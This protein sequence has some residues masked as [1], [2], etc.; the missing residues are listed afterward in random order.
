MLTVRPFSRK[1]NGILPQLVFGDTACHA[2]NDPIDL[3]QLRI[4]EHLTSGN[5]GLAVAIAHR[6]FDWCE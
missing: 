6:S 2:C 4:A 5:S 3:S 1:C